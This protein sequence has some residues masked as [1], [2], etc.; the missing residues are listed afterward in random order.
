MVFAC[1]WVCI[2]PAYINSK[3]TLAEGRRISKGKCVENPTF[4]EIRDVLDAAGLNVSELELVFIDKWSVLPKI[5]G[6]DNASV[7][8]DLLFDC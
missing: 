4:Q 8:Y 7:L 1:R 3:K 2:Y 6:Y 5:V